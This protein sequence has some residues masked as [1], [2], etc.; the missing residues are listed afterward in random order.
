MPH[1]A[2]TGLLG[3]RLAAGRTAEIYVW[4]EGQV[5]KL[6]QPWVWAG[7]PEKEQ[8]HTAAARALGLPVP[9]VGEL[10]QLEG[11]TGLSFERIPGESMMARLEREPAY[12]VEAARELARLH[13]DLHRRAA[14]AALP[15]QREVLAGRLAQ[16]PRLVPAER[17]AALRALD[18]LPVGDRLCHGDFHPGNVLL[19][20]AGPVIIDWIDASRGNPAADLARTSLLFGGHMATNP[21]PAAQRQIMEHFHH[22]YLT[23]YLDAAPE[24]E[25]EY[26]RWFPL[27]AAARLCEGITEQEDWLHQQL[28]EGLS[29]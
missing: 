27:M 15:A 4:G 18:R 10:V 1:R 5:L 29:L 3:E 12:A 6:C 22:S 26:R 2:G 23:A 28:S 25:D 21:V 7:D 19:A 9:A 17:E 20:P 13:L 8:R 11:R 14:P 24:R 16:A